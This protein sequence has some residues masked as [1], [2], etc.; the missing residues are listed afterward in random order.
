MALVMEPISKWT[1]KQVLDWMKGWVTFV[2]LVGRTRMM[3]V[4]VVG[5]QRRATLCACVCPPLIT[6]PRAD[7]RATPFGTDQFKAD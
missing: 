1:P 3:V 7:V 6:N 4:V 2:L 5:E